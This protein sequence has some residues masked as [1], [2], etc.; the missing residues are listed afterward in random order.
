MTFERPDL[1][2]TVPAA[3]G[4]LA[5]AFLLHVL[6][7]RRTGRAFGGFEPARRLTGVN[8]GRV[9]VVRYVLVALGVSAVALAGTGPRDP[10]PPRV[11]PARPVA[12][13]VVVDLSR[14]MGVDDVQPSRIDR[15]KAVTEAILDLLPA[16][17]V[18]LVTFAN[19]SYVLAP[20]TNDHEVVRYFLEPL[21]PTLLPDADH[22]T[23][24]I[25]ALRS[26]GD[27]LER[28]ASED[29]HR[30]V[31]LISDGE[32]H[33]EEA[34][35]MSQVAALREAEVRVFTVGVGTEEGT[36]LARLDYRGNPTTPFLGPDGEPVVTAL[37][38]DFLRRVADEGGGRYLDGADASGETPATA[39]LDDLGR[40]PPDRRQGP[41]GG[42]RD[43]PYALGL[44]GLVLLVAESAG[45]A[46][47]RRRGE[48]RGEGSR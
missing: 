42:G 2:W 22:G 8:L 1:L 37:H 28:H 10:D 39:L 29:S 33:E 48:A 24:T 41:E 44:I 35:V 16:D 11:E 13:V 38:P 15:A 7:R 9:P 45:E 17:R 47:A 12:A 43:I 20:P 14:S 23:R 31:V 26:A 32:S 5:V 36:T 34:R 4:V 21:E 25:E 27:L 18:G 19:Q 46:V 3:L 6:R 40:E 30:I